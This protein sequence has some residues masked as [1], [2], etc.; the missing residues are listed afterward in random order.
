MPRADGYAPAAER[1]YRLTQRL[2]LG[3]VS[4]EGSV[5]F[6]TLVTKDRVPWMKP[7]TNCS[8]V[9]AVLTQWQS[10]RDG[11]II[12]AIVMPDHL[13]ALVELSSALS[14]GRLVARWKTKTMEATNYAGRWQRDFWEHRLRCE[15]SW[16]DFGLYMFLNPYR[17]G[18]TATDCQWHGWYCPN[19]SRFGFMQALKSPGVPPPEWIGWPADR[20][21]SLA[22]GEFPS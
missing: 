7:Q 4:A 17:A 6:L 15:E 18:L 16:D 5:Y 21:R 3:R 1:R 10:E 2:H 19:P 22:I 8:L 11:T 9:K 14:V 20:F 12:G 13:H